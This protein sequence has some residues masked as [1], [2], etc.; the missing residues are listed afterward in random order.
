MTEKNFLQQ[1]LTLT[2]IETMDDDNDGCVHEAEFLS[3]MLVAL[4]RVDKEEIDTLLHLF[5]KL[6]VDNSGS[7]NRKDLRHNVR[8]CLRGEESD[9]GRRSTTA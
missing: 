2:D 5:H 7:L 4:Q 1:C 3:Y 8:T 6:D 9:R